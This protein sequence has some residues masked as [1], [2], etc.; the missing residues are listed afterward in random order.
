MD[1]LYTIIIMAGT[2][3]LAISGTLTALERKF[4]FFG[5]LIIA[6]ITAV[7]GGTTRDVLMNKD[8]FWMEEPM[9]VYNIIVGSVFAFIFRKKIDYLRTTLFLFDT[10]GLALFTIIGAKIGLSYNLNYLICIILAVMT[11]VLGGI[12]RDI[13]LSEIPIIFRKEVYATI[14]IAGA[15]LYVLLYILNVKYL[16]LEIA[17][18]V[19]MIGARLIVVKYKISLPDM[20]RDKN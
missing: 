15:S 16:I 1:I 18:I 3:A 17:P 5:V 2:F 8:V 14:S 7:G 11:G 12:L 6:F 4:D 10:V 13:I 19:F 20:Y 9:Y